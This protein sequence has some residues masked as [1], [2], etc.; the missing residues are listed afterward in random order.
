VSDATPEQWLPIPGFIGYSVSDRGRVM[1]SKRKNPRVLATQRWAERHKKPY[2]AVGLCVN[3]KSRLYVI[4]KLVLLAF[5]G[6][7]PDGQ[8]V[9]H[10]NGDARDNRLAN[11]AYGTHVENMADILRH[12]NRIGF[13]P[14]LSP[15]QQAEVVTLRRGGM[16]YQRIAD[17]FGVSEKTVRNI[18][19]GRR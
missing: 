6:K 8:E 18:I 5:V 17:R 15:D 12:G 2:L 16:T 3:G 4:H 10:L 14:K 9:R 7:R 11:L 1:S 13:A 19:L